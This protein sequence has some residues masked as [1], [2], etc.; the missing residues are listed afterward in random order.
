LLAIVACSGGSV[1][2]DPVGERYLALGDS[3]TIGTGATAAQSFPAVLVQ[4]WKAAGRP[5]T[6]TNPAVNGYTTDDLIARELPLAATVKPTLVTVLIGSNDI[7]RGRSADQYRAQLQRIYAGLAAAGVPGRALVALPQPDW[8]VSPAAARFGSPA[9]LRAT[10]EAFNQIAK[11]E[12]ERAGGRYVDL[13]PLM[14]RQADNKQLAGDGLHPSAA[15]YA[16]WAAM[17][18]PLL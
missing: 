4:R 3:F 2:Q 7:V 14:R 13:F 12:V 1:A 6:L 9:E 11:E 17:L 8:S 15:A 16:E 18:E 10:I 5:V